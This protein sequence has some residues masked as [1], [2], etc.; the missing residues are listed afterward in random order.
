MADINEQFPTDRRQI[1]QF[2]VNQMKSMQ[3][4]ITAL[5]NSHNEQKEVVSDL[6]TNIRLILQKIDDIIIPKV[7]EHEQV[8]RGD[9]KAPTRNGLVNSVLAVKNEQKVIKWVYGAFWSIIVL[10]IGAAITSFMTGYA[11]YVISCLKK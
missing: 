5:Y 1:D 4:D 11:G 3:T 10:V 8:L 7:S 9:P 2:I 6:N